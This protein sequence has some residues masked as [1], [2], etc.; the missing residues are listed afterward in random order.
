MLANGAAA[1]RASYKGLDPSA[2]DYYVS[3]FSQ[4]GVLAA[5]L[6]HFRAIDYDEWAGLP[7]ATMPTL[8]VWSPADPYLAPATAEATGKHVSGPYR[9]VVVEE[10]GHWIPELAAA[11]FSEMILEHVG[12]HTRTRAPATA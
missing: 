5:T 1:L 12:A 9:A 7:P 2:V 3:F 8:F 6:A 10:V 4:P 11:Q